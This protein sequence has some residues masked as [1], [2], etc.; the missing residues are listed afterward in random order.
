SILLVE[1]EV[2]LALEISDRAYVFD[3]GRVVDEGSSEDLLRRD[4]IR[5]TYLSL[6]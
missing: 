3:L 5:R 2:S 4:S 6:K 1:Q